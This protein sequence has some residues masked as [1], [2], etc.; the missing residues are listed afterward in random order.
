MIDALAADALAVGSLGGGSLAGAMA[1]AGAMPLQTA[2]WASGL[3]GEQRLYWY[4]AA[5]SAAVAFVFLVWTFRLPSRRRRYALVSVYAAVVL[6]A[7]YA[8]MANGVL[9]YEALDGSA[10]P[11]T[12]FVGYLFGINV[13]I[14]TVGFVGGL[15]RRL[16]AALVVP[17]L[18]ILLGTLGSWFLQPPL[19]SLASLSSLLSLP[20]IAY[21]LLGP[22]ASSASEVGDDRRLLYGKL[23]NVVLL[24][25]L[26]YLVVG[27][28]SRQNLALL[29]AFVGVFLGTYIDVLLHIGFGAILLRGGNAIDQMVRG[30]GDVDDD[31]GGGD[32]LDGAADEES[33]ATG[34]E[35]DADS[36]V[37]TDG[38]HS[39][40]GG[41]ETTGPDDT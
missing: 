15:S 29:D 35:T 11:V 27:I 17:F 12:R 1:N 24:A 31:A 37:A 40:D 3:I 38:G 4:T 25:W 32:G 13:L 28:T 2:E 7:T 34:A 30:P 10:V 6:S 14:Q 16:R 19:A 26:G 36:M 18:G 5:F 9:R 33:T 21:L 39:H 8:G 20:L 23:A 22:G 41:C